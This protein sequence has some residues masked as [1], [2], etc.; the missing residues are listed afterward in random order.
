[1]LRLAIAAA[2]SAAAMYM[3]RCCCRHYCLYFAAVA[4]ISFHFADYFSIF[5]LP[6]IF[7]FDY[8]HAAAAYAP[9][10]ADALLTPFRYFA[11]TMLCAYAIDVL[12][13]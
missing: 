2:S 3:L 10:L 4:D 5:M 1:M 12:C 8:F 7:F 9:P 6:L 13:A 11:A